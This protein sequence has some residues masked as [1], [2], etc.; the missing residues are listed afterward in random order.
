MQTVREFFAFQFK[1]VVNE[2]LEGN[3]VEFRP[4][5]SI[6]EPE[7]LHKDSKGNK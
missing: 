4:A 2:V 3:G 6:F 5:K 1:I 7:K